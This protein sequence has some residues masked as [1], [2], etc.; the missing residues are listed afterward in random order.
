MLPEMK[1]VA[2]EKSP[3]KIYTSPYK[4]IHQISHLAIEG[5]GGGHPDGLQLGQHVQ[6]CEV[7]VREAV[8]PVCR[9]IPRLSQTCSGNLS[10][11]RSTGF[12]D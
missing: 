4:A 8:Y 3:F 5:V 7:Q 10:R 2:I 11:I 12:R 1:H 9:G 6:L